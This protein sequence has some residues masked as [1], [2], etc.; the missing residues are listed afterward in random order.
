MAALAN[1]NS[2][3]MV[4]WRLA[5]LCWIGGLPLYG[6]SCRLRGEGGGGRGELQ[7][8]VLNFTLHRKSFGKISEQSCKTLVIPTVSIP[9]Q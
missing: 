7:G 6:G 1:W 5:A 2:A 8:R 3:C 4:D 9:K